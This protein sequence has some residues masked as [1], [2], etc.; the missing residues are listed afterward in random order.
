MATLSNSSS[1]ITRSLNTNGLR[2]AAYACALRS[3][4]PDEKNAISASHSGH[5]STG[6]LSIISSGKVI[7]RNSERPSA[8][9]AVSRLSVSS[10]GAD[11]AFFAI[12]QTPITIGPSDMRR[13]M[14]FGMSGEPLDAWEERKGVDLETRNGAGGR[15]LGGWSGAA[16]AVCAETLCLTGGALMRGV[17]SES[18]R[19]YSRPSSRRLAPRTGPRSQSSMRA[20]CGHSAR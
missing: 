6:S 19:L 16:M 5:L 8:M 7:T 15:S 18:R 13:Q 10:I 14:V 17:R 2:S 9:K 20:R 1:C 12:A 3:G 4:K 11:L